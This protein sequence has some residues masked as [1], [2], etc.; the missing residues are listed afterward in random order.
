MIP[1]LLYWN[2][3]IESLWRTVKNVTV[4]SIHTKAYSGP[5]TATQRESVEK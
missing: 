2:E 4:L 1:N 3:R 5:Q